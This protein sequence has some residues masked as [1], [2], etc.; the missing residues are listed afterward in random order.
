MEG[1]AEHLDVEVNGVASQIAL[2]PA[3]VT[4]F[5]DET[6]IGRQD[7]IAGLAYEELESAFLEQR[8]QWRQPCGADFVRATIAAL[9]GHR[10]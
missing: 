4:V 9:G 2:G 8:N 5:D 1:Q 6:G 10:D 3:P 7:K